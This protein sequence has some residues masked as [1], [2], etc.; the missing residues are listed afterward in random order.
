M[1]RVRVGGAYVTNWPREPWDEAAQH[2]FICKPVLCVEPH[3]TAASEP[4]LRRSR[5]VPQIPVTGL[6][7]YPP[8]L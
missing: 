6:G 3:V 7:F 8:S 1:L 2:S 5:D 4:R